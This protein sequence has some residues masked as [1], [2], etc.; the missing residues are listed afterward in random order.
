MSSQTR[1]DGSSD[2]S[3]APAPTPLIRCDS[4]ASDELFERDAS[5]AAGAILILCN[6]LALRR[7]RKPSGSPHVA[8]A[9]QEPEVPSVR[10]FIW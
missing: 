8:P 10:P 9:S 6:M 5:K 3:S 1:S 2:G 4:L 7:A